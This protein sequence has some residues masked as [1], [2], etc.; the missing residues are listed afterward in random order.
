MS[1]P[2]RPSGGGIDKLLQRKVLHILEQLERRQRVVL[3]IR[4]R[5]V[6]R[7]LIAVIAG[8]VKGVIE[9]GGQ[10]AQGVIGNRTENEIDRRILRHIAMISADSRLS[11]MTVWRVF[12]SI[13]RRTSAIPTNPAPPTTSTEAP[14]KT[15][16][17]MRRPARSADANGLPRRHAHHTSGASARSSL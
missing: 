7:R 4:E 3:V 15:E 5:V 16:A 17:F 2:R 11:T 13:R 14:A 12:A 9:I 6:D 1:S 10:S 8:Q